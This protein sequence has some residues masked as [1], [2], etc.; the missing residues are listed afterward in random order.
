MKVPSHWTRRGLPYHVT[1]GGC[2]SP[3]PPTPPT[4]QPNP[5]SHGDFTGRWGGSGLHYD[6]QLW[7]RLPDPTLDT[8]PHSHPGSSWPSPPTLRGGGK[9]HR[10]SSIL[11]PCKRRSTCHSPMPKPEQKALGGPLGRGLCLSP[12]SSQGGCAGGKLGWC[13]LWLGQGAQHGNGMNAGLCLAAGNGDGETRV[14]V[15]VSGEVTATQR[16]GWGEGVEAGE[17]GQHTVT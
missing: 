14:P 16:R 17:G 3:P 9:E 11:L 5:G 10:C 1:P 12:A 13:R 6:G 4:H 2:P 8:L 7:S 15:W